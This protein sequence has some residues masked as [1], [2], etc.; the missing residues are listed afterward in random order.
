MGLRQHVDTGLAVDAADKLNTAVPKVFVQQADHLNAFA[1]G[2]LGNKCVVVTTGLVDALTPQELKAIISHEL[3]H[4]K[5]GHTVWTALTGS[6][7]LLGLPVFDKIMALYFLVWS[8]K[9][10]Y[11]CDRGA[12]LGCRDVNAVATALAKLATG[13]E[14]FGKFDMNVFLSQ[15]AERDEN[16]L[17]RWSELL[18]THPATVD[19]IHAVTDFAQSEKYLK[20][21]AAA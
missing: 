13:K 2:L 1:S 17:G 12:L 14:L 18:S 5:C 19:R 10:E 15:K 7:E 9:A 3:S 16:E 8:R 20:L 6:A 21:I 4:L 11:T